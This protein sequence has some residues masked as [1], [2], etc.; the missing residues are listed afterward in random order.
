VQSTFA[1]WFSRSLQPL[2]ISKIS[3]AHAN[4]AKYF[5]FSST[6]VAFYAMTIRREISIALLLRKRLLHIFVKWTKW[7]SL[8]FQR[9]YSIRHYENISNLN[10][11]CRFLLIW[12]T[13]L[14][15]AVNLLMNIICL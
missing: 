6:P 2:C 13:K 12:L 10:E 7:I 9:L 5:P 3:S 1:K 11:T 14:T 4:N 8:C 15:Q